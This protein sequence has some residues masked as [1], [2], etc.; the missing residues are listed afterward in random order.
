LSPHASRYAGDLIPRNYHLQHEE[1]VKLDS[2]DPDVPLPQADLD[3]VGNGFAATC[4][5]EEA[6]KLVED[7]T[8]TTSQ[9]I[10]MLPV[11]MS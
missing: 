6:G 11:V 5:E 1:S 10:K 8:E 9:V 3:V 7:S 2:Q 4:T